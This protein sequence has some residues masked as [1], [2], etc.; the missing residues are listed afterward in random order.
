[1]NSSPTTLNN[2]L[3][4]L[5][6]TCLLAPVSLTSLAQKTITN[7]LVGFDGKNPNL[8]IVKVSLGDTA[9]VLN[10]ETTAPAGNWIRIPKNTYIQ[11]N[12]AKEKL[13]IKTTKGIP[14]NK[15][16]IMPASGKTSYELVFPKIATTTSMIDYGEDSGDGWKIYDI[17]LIKKQ[18]PLPLS[19]YTEWYNPKNSDLA[20]AFY[21]KAVI[22]DQQV[23]TYQAITQ[24][25]EHYNLTLS[26]NKATKQITVEKLAD[27]ELNLAIGKLSTRLSSNKESCAQILSKEVYQLPLLKNDS[28][29]FSGYIKNYSAKLNTKT[30]M[31]A[32]DNIIT[33][34]QENALVNIEPNGYFYRKIPVYHLQRVFLR[35]DVADENDIYLE[36]GKTLFVVLGNGPIKYTGSAAQLNESLRQLNSI[37]QYNYQRIQE[38]LVN[39][40]PNDYKTYLLGLQAIEQ[41]K[42]DSLNQLGK[43]SAKAYQVKKKDIL[44]EYANRM[45][46]YHWNYEYAYRSAFKLPDIATVNVEAYPVGYYNFINNS[47]FN[48][49]L[50][51]ISN[52]Y[53]TFINRIK[54]IPGFRMD[55]YT[56]N[57]KD[58]TAALKLSGGQLSKNDIAFEKLISENGLSLST[59]S[60]SAPII[61]KW[62]ADHKSFV[63]DFVS[64]AFKN[65][66]YTTLDS[67]TGIKQG[68]LIDLMRSQDIA[69]PVVSQLTPLDTKHLDLAKQQISNPFLK[70]YIELKNN[71]TLK[72]IEINKT[73]SGYFVN[74]T[75][76][77]EADKIF[78]NIMG[79]YAGKVILVDFWATWCG[80]CLNGI[81]EIKP[82]KEEMKDSN[83]AFVYITNETSPLATYQNMTPGIKGQHYRL[84]NDA[85]R[86]LADKFKITGIPHQVLVNKEGKVVNPHLGFLDNKEIKQLLEKQL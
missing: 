53:S 76:K 39:M 57:Y 64:N 81:K 30:L 45:M 61:K 56:Y 79:K 17:E 58:I 20:I 47:D 62:N 14:F 2:L 11:V 65:R 78:D 25:G 21:N 43:V 5:A 51:V 80:P 54:F 71:E 48:N 73:S 28:A 75:P 32:I 82:L 3:K 86:Y 67:A 63:N 49:E 36:P 60:V 4:G 70:E 12:G 59:D 38:K 44:L 24:N 35:S 46:E 33:G 55:S 69:K 9:T 13:F 50:N 40:K 83:V 42:L 72:Q 37:D 23:W 7:P 41:T 29:V 16:Y 26:N 31:L 27:N 66:Y 22:L 74:E 68:I 19:L 77:V 6:L 84:D 1:M 8:K 15:Q 18:T 10:F 52:G 85:W 34:E